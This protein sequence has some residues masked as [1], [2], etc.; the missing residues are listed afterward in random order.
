M[1]AKKIYTTS[2]EYQKTTTNTYEDSKD[3][4]SPNA[5]Q[6]SSNMTVVPKESMSLTRARTYI[7]K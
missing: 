2:L 6:L 7:M 3:P 5:H 4:R 1:Q